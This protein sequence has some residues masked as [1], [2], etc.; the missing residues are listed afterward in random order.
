ML[1]T[2]RFAIVVFV[3]LLVCGPEPVLAKGPNWP[4]W[5]GPTRNGL[6]EETG[7]LTAWPEGGPKLLWMKN[8][9]G[10]GYSGPAVVDGVLFTLGSRDGV[11]MALAYD[12]STGEEVW[13]GKIGDEYENN[14]GNG[15][16]STPAVS[17]GR[18]YALGAQGELVCF[19]AKDGAELWR[20]SLIEMGGSIPNWGYSESPL[21]EG[22]VVVVTPGGEQGALAALDCQTGEVIWRSTELTD[23][24]HYASIVPAVIQ[25]K[26]QYV[27]LL[28]KRLV[29]V[30]R[31]T[32]KLLW[33]YGWPGEVAVIPTPIIDGDRVYMTSGYGVGCAM[34]TITPE[35]KVEEAFS[36][37]RMKNHHGGVVL[38]DGH[39]FGHSDQVGWVCQEL[40]TGKMKWREEGALDKGAIAYAD[41]HFYCIGEDSGDV[42]LIEATSEGWKQKG[43]FK[44]TPQTKL[45]KDAG[46]I[47]THPVVVDG[48]L[49]LRDQELL[50][51]FD[52]RGE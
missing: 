10:L 23:T 21:V 28:P 30:A 50:F 3:C 7:L 35:F 1:S 49:Y 17:G 5:Q 11:E 32:G 22:G 14:W 51:C 4:Q 38:V 8:S 25:G 44:L 43:R 42:A 26:P 31:D 15:P 34:V 19:A 36:N 2:L 16:R 39:V 41:G 24:A 29:G 20:K 46:R 40:E 18:V 52:V 48:K 45:R 33:E 27:Q 12:A 6:T 9:A 13:A 47:W 37:K